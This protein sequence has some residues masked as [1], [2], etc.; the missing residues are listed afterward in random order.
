MLTIFPWLAFAI[1]RGSRDQTEF[2][3]PLVFAFPVSVLRP[4]R[5][6]QG[7]ASRRVRSMSLGRGLSPHA[8]TPLFPLC[9]PLLQPLSSQD[10]SP[11]VSAL[12]GLGE[13]C[14]QQTATLD[15][16]CMTLNDWS[17]DTGFPKG[18]AEICLCLEVPLSQRALNTAECYPPCHSCVCVPFPSVGAGF[19]EVGV[20]CLM[21]GVDV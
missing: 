11:S 21:R 19:L 13:N 7:R 6:R 5:E 1:F 2:S 9:L 4:T 8:C 3:G 17:K 10:Q 18:R 15:L 16:N 20:E 14:R 12:L